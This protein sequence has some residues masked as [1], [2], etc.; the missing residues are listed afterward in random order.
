V[1][2]NLADVPF[3][4]ALDALAMRKQAL[5]EGAAPRIPKSVLANTHFFETAGREYVKQAVSL[6]GTAEAAKNAWKAQT[7]ELKQ[8]LAAAGLGA[9]VGGVGAYAQAPKKQ[10]SWRHALEG[11]LIGGSAGGALS[12]ADNWAGTGLG[13]RA[14]DGARSAY[15]TVSTPEGRAKLQQRFTPQDVSEED[16]ANAAALN[17]VANGN[18]K[19]DTLLGAG[20]VH[21]VAGGINL[22]RPK[23]DAGLAADQVRREVL[24]P[25]A[26]ATGAPTVGHFGKS[27][28][29]IS[30]QQAEDLHDVIRPTGLFDRLRGRQPT[31]TQK[32]DWLLRAADAKS[33]EFAEMQRAMSGGRVARFVRSLNPLGSGD[34]RYVRKVL[35]ALPDQDM[36][37]RILTK[38]TTRGAS[39]G[40]FALSQLPLLGADFA[41]DKINTNRATRAAQS[42][43]QQAAAANDTA[44]MAEAK[45]LLS[46][47]GAALP[48]G[49]P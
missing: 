23:V 38:S 15:G 14:I 49:T 19:A 17:T 26:K 12:M 32:Q 48:G 46:Y 27:R 44:R 18:T 16:G 40:R 2:E 11:A 37:Q 6:S 30:G 3:D 7:P 36:A 45:K 47:Y 25:S 41:I 9:A 43:Y 21:G 1:I 34:R 39:P 42:A 5:D 4:D 20:A 22:A 33:R 10:R 31:P 13:R 28:P 8:N 24:R 29:T 35:D